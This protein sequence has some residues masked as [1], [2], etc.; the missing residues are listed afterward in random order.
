MPNRI[1]LRR[2]TT[3]GAARPTSGVLVGEIFANTADK[4]L[5]LGTSTTLTEEIAYIPNDVIVNPGDVVIGVGAGAAGIADAGGA[6][7]GYVLT[8]DT[9]SEPNV[10]WLPPTTDTLT[11]KGDLLTRNTTGLARLPIGATNGH[12]LTVDSAA[13]T[14]MKWEAAAGGGGSGSDETAVAW[15]LGV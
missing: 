9:G 6:A 1:V 3:T 13:A 11:T 10:F 7:T 4:K 14:G 8:F 15:F 2:S 12:V 5:F